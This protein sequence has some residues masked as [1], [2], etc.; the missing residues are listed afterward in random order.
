MNT[1]IHLRKHCLR[2]RLHWTRTYNNL[3][4]G[5][6]IV[7]TQF[8]ISTSSIV[9]AEYRGTKKYCSI[10]WFWKSACYQIIKISKL[11]SNGIR[12]YNLF[13]GRLVIEYVSQKIPC[14]IL[15]KVLY[16]HFSHNPIYGDNN[17]FMLWYYKTCYIL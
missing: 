4:S 9:L 16:I 1:T 10:I 3:I 12:W 15:R 13:T 8:I 6:R 14:T 17:S 5:K 11:V 2:L 7:N